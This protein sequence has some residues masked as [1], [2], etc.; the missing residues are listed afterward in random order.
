MNKQLANLADRRATLIEKIEVQRMEMA[1]ISGNLHR[2]MGIVDV[3]LKGVRF[4]YRHPVVVAG[5]LT[6]LLIWRRKGIGGVAEKGWHWLYRY[7]SAILLVLK[8]IS[9]ATHFLGKE[10]N[11]EDVSNESP[12]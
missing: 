10:R 6:A 11:A 12:S 1:G 4:V 3:G 5:G 7:P 2:A 8:L 9:F